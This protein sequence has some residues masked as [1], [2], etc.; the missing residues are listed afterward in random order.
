MDKEN[1]SSN[2]NMSGGTYHDLF[3]R[4]SNHPDDKSSSSYL[5]S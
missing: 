3:Y 1:T 4:F 2:N 5:L